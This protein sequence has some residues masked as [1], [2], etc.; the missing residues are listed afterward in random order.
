[1]QCSPPGPD[2]FSG[3]PYFTTTQAFPPQSRSLIYSPELCRPGEDCMA[4]RTGFELGV[5]F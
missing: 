5:P 2:R 3:V 1:M 4:V